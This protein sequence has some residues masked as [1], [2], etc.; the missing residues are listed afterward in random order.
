M[1]EPRQAR[2]MPHQASLP[3]MPMYSQQLTRCLIN[4]HAGKPQTLGEWQSACHLQ[5]IIIRLI[6]HSCPFQ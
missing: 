4:E 2:Y 6:C 5:H 1:H 3:S